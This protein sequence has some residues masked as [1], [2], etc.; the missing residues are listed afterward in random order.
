MSRREMARAG[1]LARVKAGGL[2][3]VDAAKLMGVCYRQ[4]KRLWAVFQE[5][6]AAG[7]KVRQRM[8]AWRLTGAPDSKS[9]GGQEKDDTCGRPEIDRQRP[10]HSGGQDMSPGSPAGKAV[11]AAPPRRGYPRK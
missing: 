11:P 4:A 2:R 7:L 1:V 10:L 8:P 3:V 9:R 6:G 5:Q